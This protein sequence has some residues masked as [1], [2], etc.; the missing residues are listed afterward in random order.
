M[1]AEPWYPVG[2]NDVFPEEFESFLGLD[3]QL[4]ETFLKHHS[5]LLDWA[6]WS[7]VQDRLGQGEIVDIYPYSGD[8]RLTA[9]R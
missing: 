4:R 2:P 7:D 6:W 8:Q 5:N 3:G 9:A 1:L